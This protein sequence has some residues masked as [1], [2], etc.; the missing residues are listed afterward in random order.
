[1]TVHEAQEILRGS[2]GDRELTDE[3]VD[4][5]MEAVKLFIYGGTP[6]M[7]ALNHAR[8]LFA[9]PQYRE[10]HKLLFVLSDGQPTDGDDPPLTALSALGVTVVSCFITDRSISDPLRLY[11]NLDPEWTEAAKFMFRMSS[12][13]RT[14]LIPRTIFV[15]RDWKIDIANNETKLFCQVNHPEIIKDVCDLAR[16][17]V[18]CQDA[19]SD[20]LA[21]VSVDVYINQTKE[22]FGAKRQKLGT[23]YANASAA[24]LHLAMKRIVGRVGGYPDFFEIR[25]K[26]IDKHGWH[27][28]NIFKVLQEVCPQ[29]RL[30]YRQVDA[31]GAVKA[32]AAKRSVIAFFFLTEEDP[33]NPGNPPYEWDSFSQ[34]YKDNPRGIL[35]RSE[36]DISKRP[37]GAKLAG[38]AVALTS[39]N[40]ECLRLMNSWGSDWADGGFFRV[41]NADVLGLEFV[42]VFWTLDDLEQEEKDAYARDGA[43]KAKQ[44]L[45][46]LQGLKSA[47]YRC[48][49]CS[50]ESNVRDFSGHLGEVKCPQCSRT[51]RVKDSGGDLALNM[52]LTSL[53]R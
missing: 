52:Y 5:L 29:Y 47:K 43:E 32:V 34:F 28:A 45:D 51:F 21:T 48:P 24:V 4:E 44:L 40:N 8:K 17:I 20:A 49:L 31:V 1:M 15:K 30:Q 41:Q 38:H 36:I 23:C 46:S 16:N 25:D 10:H 3:R 9:L 33:K 50:V 7:K 53:S 18:C 35:T 22:R 42:D 37:Y 14:E 39:Y 27:G 2:V 26:L 12:S 13:I 6:L 19:L 11:S